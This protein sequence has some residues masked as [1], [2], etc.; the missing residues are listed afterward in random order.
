MWTRV[1]L[2]ITL[3]VPFLGGKV[4]ADDHDAAIAELQAQLAEAVVARNVAEQ[5]GAELRASLTE[6]RKDLADLRRQFADVLVASREREAETEQLRL[7]IAAL[8]F[9]SDEDASRAIAAKAVAALHGVHQTNAA[10]HTGVRQFADYLQGVVDALETS[11]AVRREIGDRLDRLQRLV[12]DAERSPS[13][14]AGRG[15]INGRSQRECRVLAVSD[16]FQ[17]VVLDV[18]AARGARLGMVW[19][20]HDRAHRPTHVL[21]LV[22]VRTSISSAVVVR[23]G[24]DG[25]APGMTVRAG[26]TED[27]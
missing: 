21:R 13:S 10:L 22:D 27:N 19:E 11:A 15:G 18:G 23:G 6:A 5:R 14:V 17:I 7:G 3:C 4:S 20:I 25:I 12:A 26:T 16:E 8:L 2:A 1:L 24:M 9:E